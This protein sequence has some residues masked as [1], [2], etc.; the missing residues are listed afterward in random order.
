MRGY[1]RPGQEQG[2]GRPSEGEAYVETTDNVEEYT[3][4][5]VWPKDVEDEDGSQLQANN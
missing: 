2:K 1:W 4:L 5:I 3:N